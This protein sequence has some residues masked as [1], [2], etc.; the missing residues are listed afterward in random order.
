MTKVLRDQFGRKSL[1]V[2]VKSVKWMTVSNLE[3]FIPC[4]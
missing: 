3:A 2:C 1:Y 4:P